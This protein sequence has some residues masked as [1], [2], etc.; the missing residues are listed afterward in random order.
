M[1]LT[2]NNGET[3]KRLYFDV[4]DLSTILDDNKKS[5]GRFGRVSIFFGFRAANE[6][7]HMMKVGD[8]G[9]RSTNTDIGIILSEPMDGRV[10]VQFQAAKP[11]FGQTGLGPGMARVS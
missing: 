10:Q 11:A 8:D 4:L 6:F 3:A 5:F 9:R 7:V 2:W 1:G